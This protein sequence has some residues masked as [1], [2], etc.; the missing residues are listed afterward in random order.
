MIL[1]FWIFQ[2]YIGFKKFS[3]IFKQKYFFKNFNKYLKIKIYDNSI[4]KWL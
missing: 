1:D 3:T 2:E 4:I